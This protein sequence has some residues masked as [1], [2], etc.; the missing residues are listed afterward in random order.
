MAGMGIGIYSPWCCPSNP[1]RMSP[2]G[3][4]QSLN[5]IIMA[6]GKQALRDFFSGYPGFRYRSSAD[7][8]DEWRRLCRHCDWPSRREDY[9]HAEREEAWQDY[10]RAMTIS[11][12]DTFGNDDCDSEAWAKLCSSAGISNV[13]RTLAERK[14]VRS[15]IL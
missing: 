6:K 14:A 7:S 11:F 9:H 10:R 3:I 1:P 8:I 12:N 15:P 5:K 2:L 13:P 4:A